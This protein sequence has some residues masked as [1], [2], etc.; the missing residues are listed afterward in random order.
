MD[1]GMARPEWSSKEAG[2]KLCRVT[3]LGL[4]RHK[5]STHCSFVIKSAQPRQET[6]LKH[7]KRQ[8]RRGKEG[9]GAPPP[10]GACV[11]RR[12]G[13]RTRLT[14]YKS[15]LLCN[16]LISTGQGQRQVVGSLPSRPAPRGEQDRFLPQLL[17]HKPWRGP[18]V[19]LAVWAGSGCGHGSVAED[20]PGALQLLPYEASQT[21]IHMRPLS[22]FKIEKKTRAKLLQCPQVMTT[23][24]EL[25]ELEPIP[26]PW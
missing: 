24:S 8:L 22:A 10:A 1:A 21:S 6:P 3:G 16:S 12:A 4:D 18:A 13:C 14:K 7:Y 26:P 17:P 23:C 19:N 9:A 15:S 11:E 25:W 2:R 5:A 20:A